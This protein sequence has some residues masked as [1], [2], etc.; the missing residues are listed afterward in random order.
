MKT[1]NCKLK[2]CKAY[3][4][5]VF[6]CLVIYS[7]IGFQHP[8]PALAAVSS[9]ENWNIQIDDININSGKPAVKKNTDLSGH[10]RLSPPA[11]T[12]K[13]AKDDADINDLNQLDFFTFSISNSIIDFGILSPTNPIYR[14]TNISLS[15]INKD[16]I[17][18]AFE[19]NPLL[20]TKSNNI[21]PDT[22]CDNG[23]CSEIRTALWEN[24]LTY[25]FGYRCDN[26]TGDS[27]PIEFDT[28]NYYK[29]FPDLSKSESPQIIMS[30]D[31]NLQSQEIQITYKVNISKTQPGG[32]YTNN[33]TYIA[34]PGY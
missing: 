10:I 23:Y 8:L 14:T 9:N 4:L 15:N 13:N 17:V 18:T 19:N 31:P 11:G 28:S 1:V 21:I 22:T 32:S 25:G 29:Q 24:T 6:L 27:C 7:I 2:I 20:I 26:V 5:T 34:S 33:I 16:Y 30:P 3:F 12:A